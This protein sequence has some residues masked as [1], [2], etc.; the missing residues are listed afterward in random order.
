MS[1]SGLICKSTFWIQTGPS[2]AGEGGFYES[3]G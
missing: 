1:S 2:G 3:G